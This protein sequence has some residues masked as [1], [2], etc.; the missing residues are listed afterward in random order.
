MPSLGSEALKSRLRGP[1]Q[2]VPIQFFR[3]AGGGL[4]SAPPSEGVH[5]L[6]TNALVTNALVYYALVTNAL[7]YYA[8]VHKCS[9]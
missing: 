8:L 1:I 5:A 9:R 7:V 3:H 2:I 6:V 4:A